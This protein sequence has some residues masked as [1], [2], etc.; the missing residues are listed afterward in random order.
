VYTHQGHHYCR[1][2]SAHSNCPLAMHRHND[3]FNVY[4]I[5]ENVDAKAALRGLN[6]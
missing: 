3:A 1:C 6:A 2:F 4:C 5:G